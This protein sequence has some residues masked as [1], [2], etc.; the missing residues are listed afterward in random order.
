MTAGRPA[1]G[2]DA[3]G[4]DLKLSGLAPNPSHGALAIIQRGGIAIAHRKGRIVEARRTIA[5]PVARRERDITLLRQSARFVRDI[6]ARASHPSSTVNQ[7]DGGTLRLIN[8][9]RRQIDID[10]ELLAVDFAIDILFW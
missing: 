5:E 9:R 8:A 6:L 2:S 3:V 10:A 4:I 7:Q 1:D